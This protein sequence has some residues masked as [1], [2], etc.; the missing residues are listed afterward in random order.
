VA[1]VSPWLPFSPGTAA[2]EQITG[3]ARIIDGDTIDVGRRRIRLYGIDAPEMHQQCRRSDARDAP[4]Y[5]CGQDAKIALAVIIGSGPVS[6]EPRDH[7]RYG[8]TV[9]VCSAQGS[10]IAREMVREG[11]AVAYMRYSLAYVPDEIAA[12]VSKRALW[13]GEFENPADWRHRRRGQ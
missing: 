6:C 4:L 11:W 3:Y 7:D 13:A 5:H 12:R 10:D 9:A 2:A 8:R 1:L